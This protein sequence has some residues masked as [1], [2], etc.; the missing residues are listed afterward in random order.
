M[1]ALCKLTVERLSLT[2]NLSHVEHHGDHDDDALDDLLQVRRNAR[3]QKAV[4][5][6]AEHQNTAEAAYNGA[7]AAGLGYT[8]DG[9][10]RDA[11]SS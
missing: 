5:D 4:V 3:N 10:R 2:G 1:P 7:D 11:V 8:A 6:N 9:G